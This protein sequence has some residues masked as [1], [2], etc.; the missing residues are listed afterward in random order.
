MNKLLPCFFILLAIS[1][2]AQDLTTA[3]KT[4]FY[5]YVFKITDREAKQIYQKDLS[6]VKDNFFHTAVDSFETDK[7][8]QKKLPLGYYLFTYAQADSL[9]FELQ[10]VS[11]LQVKLLNNKN[12]LA[13]HLHDSAGHP[14]TQ[15]NVRL[16]HHRIPFDE[17]TQSYRLHNTNRR[18]FLEIEYQSF[19]MYQSIDARYKTNRFKRT[20]SRVLFGKPLGWLTLPFYSTYWSLKRHRPQ[21]IVLKVAN[22]FD[23]D[24]RERTFDSDTREENRERR[25]AGKNRGFLLFNQPRY[26]PWD[27]VRMKA[28]L[29]RKG[30]P[31]REKVE[32]WLNYYSQ[33]KSKE[34]LLT[35]LPPY[36]KGAFEFAFVL[37]D[38]LRIQQ[39]TD[40][41]IILRKPMKEDK[42][43][44]YRQGEFRFEDYELKK[45]TYTFRVSQKDFYK[46]EKVLLFAKGT[47]ENNLNVPDATVRLT[48]L[49]HQ[50]VKFTDPLVF[51]KDTTWYYEQK[52]D[53]VGETKIMLPDSLWAN[54]EIKYS[55]KAEFLNADNEKS[56]SNT[57]FTCHFQTATYRLSLPNDSLKAEYLEAGV[58]KPK[59]ALLVSL[60]EKDEEIERKTVHLPYYERLNPYAEAYK[61]QD[62][63]PD[64]STLATLDLMEEPARLEVF[65]SRSPDSVKIDVANPRHLPFWYTIYYKNTRLDASFSH[66]DLIFRHKGRLKQ[67]YF[68]SL[69][70]VWNNK[71]TEAEYNLPLA[72]RELIVSSQQPL[73]AEPGQTVPFRITVKDLHGR[74]V[75][76][77][78]ITAYGIT[79]KFTELTSPKIPDFSTRYRTRKLINTFSLKNRFSE[80]PEDQLKLNWKTYKRSM[81]LDS[82]AY[83]KFLY[84]ESGR[85]LFYQKTANNISQVAPFVMEN[86]ELLQPVMVFL[87]EE[88]VYFQVAEAG[89]RYSFPADSG[90]HS[91]RIRTA[92]KRLRI[93]SLFVRKGEKLVCSFDTRLP[94]KHQKVDS[95]GS[96]LTYSELE[97]LNNYLMPF[98]N[99]FGD[100]YDYLVQGKRVFLLNTPEWGRNKNYNSRTGKYESKFVQV[101]PLKPALTTFV[102][103]GGFKTDFFFES[104][105]EYDFQPGLLKMRGWQPFKKITLLRE[106]LPYIPNFKALAYTET[107]L[108]SLY[109]FSREKKT[110]PVAY[111]DNPYRTT[112]SSGKL[113]LHEIRFYRNTTAPAREVQP[114]EAFRGIKHILVFNEADPNFLRIYPGSERTFQDLKPGSYHLFFLFYYNLFAESQPF[115]IQK[116]GTNYL[117]CTLDSLHPAASRSHLLDS[118]VKASVELTMTAEETQQKIKENYYQTYNILQP[119]DAEFTNFVEGTVRDE[120]GEALP[121]VNV[122][123]KGTTVGTATDA[124][125]YYRI[126]T[127][128]NAVLVYSFVGYMFKEEIVG[129]SSVIDINLR[130]DIRALNEVVVVGYSTQQ[131]KDVT[132]AVSV[133]TTSLQGRVAGVQVTSAD[134]I[135]IRGVNTLYPGKKPLIL[136]DG[137]E[138]SG[139]LDAALI[140]SVQTLK[141]DA[142]LALYGAKAANG[143]VLITTRNQLASK[144]QAEVS[145]AGSSPKSAI[146][147]HFRDYTFWQPRLRTDRNGEVTFRATLPD[148]ITNW[149][150]FVVAVADKKRLGK[151]ESSLKAFKSLFANL[152]VPRFLV[153][154]D[155]AVI[156]GKTLNYTTDT[157]PVTTVF[158]VNKK[159]VFRRPSLVVNA[160]IDSVTVSPVATDSLKISYFL[161]KA[162]GISDG[163][164]RPVPVIAKGIQETKGTFMSLERDTTATLTFDKKLGTVT[165]FAQS[166]VLEIL[167]DESRHIQH[168][169]YLCNEQLAS[170]LKS[171]LAERQILLLLGKPFTKE[172]DILQ[173]IGKLEATQKAEGLWGWWKDTPPAVWVSLHV[174]EAL[175][176]AQQ[177][178]FAVKY[179]PKGLTDYLVFELE[180][181]GVDDKLKTLKLLHSL[182]AALDFPKKIKE[183]ERLM[184]P[185]QPSAERLRKKLL[186]REEIQEMNR[187]I[188]LI[189]Q[190]QLLELKQLTGLPCSLDTLWKKQKSTIFG[191][192]YWGEATWHPYLDDTQTTLLAYRILERKGGF[193]SI[194]RKI[195]GYF[196]EKRKTG[197]W[198][199]TYES[200]T[201]LETLLPGLLSNEKT[202]RPA[203]LTLKTGT[204]TQTITNFPFTTQLTENQTLDIQKTGTL[205]VYFTAYQTFQNE[206]PEKVEK[207]FVVHTTFKGLKSSQY[208]LKA[209]ETIT[210]QAELEVKKDADFVLVE[211][212]IPAGCSYSSS[213][214]HWNS[215]I[216]GETYREAFFNK[217]SIYCSHLNPGKYTFEVQLV[218]RYHGNFT[219]NPAKAE[220]MYFPVFF[221]RNAMQKVSIR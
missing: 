210:L 175:M 23:S 202:I 15:A 51:V 216:Y 112:P 63:P 130:G 25:F 27:T 125:G 145:T 157:V 85:S 1:S 14:V 96:E 183:I 166:N 105:F 18:G 55:V 193:E 192:L 134:D 94:H 188:P 176:Q 109:R 200:A 17:A 36:R 191:S 182:G 66:N 149:R 120:N 218:A 164:R 143:V 39:R 65:T 34:V 190:L 211:I 117:K 155:S 52:L 8:Y 58:S 170:K 95:V 194:L 79:K 111:Y 174:N 203:A 32:V 44:L 26:K 168:Y 24:W 158:E 80:N 114:G 152:A 123:V 83:Y 217:T 76:N 11:K 75:A 131:R 99:N 173:I 215:T 196:L 110:Y 150:T 108:D 33:G 22:L 71:I 118:L 102:Q 115:S 147:T 213:T 140:A 53:A 129:H 72:N 160:V 30:R 209:G 122:V 207:D 186:S 205:P 142:A 177:A 82:L 61:L 154:G 198:N 16:K 49:P 47:D 161:Q 144:N 113:V 87:D 107:E 64:H 138:F 90:W 43:R 151:H 165:I 159:E 127:P 67:H 106:H 185:H 57:E 73:V 195:R 156:I 132:G 10:T 38:S 208:T 100:S 74:P 184:Q 104:G 46:G 139:E 48:V 206:T 20:L 197:H 60:T 78:D 2:H 153:V 7:N 81:G 92:H 21:G 69:Q 6:I 97:V 171:L 219:L 169:E 70:Y 136:V 137:L 121:G 77:A 133:V 9:V 93:D 31:V 116:N 86:G 126:Y 101:A 189:E 50:F 201:I 212:P 4:S 148:D 45:N 220:L 88:P 41:Q 3:R 29:F 35:T 5:T 59:T 98:R 141:P 128:P 62:L 56:D 40:C 204:A 187:T 179:N 84:P 12:D 124:K 167:L 214:R 19:T 146:R 178:G 68:L 103:K 119:P 37:H 89:Q 13:I 163:E 162:G 28:V 221:G 181:Q 135:R 199:N 180:K 42:I 54:A 91:L 172:T